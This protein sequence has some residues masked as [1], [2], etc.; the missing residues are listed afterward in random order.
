MALLTYLKEQIEKGEPAP[1]IPLEFACGRN[2]I[3]G[4]SGGSGSSTQLPLHRH[5]YYEIF[6][7]VSDKISHKVDDKVMRLA[8]NTIC[9]VRPDDAH[10][11]IYPADSSDERH[12]LNITFSK[13]V[14]DHVFT[15]LQETGINREDFLN[16]KEPPMRILS[17]MQ[18]REFLLEFEKRLQFYAAE[19]ET[20]RRNIY[21]FL[22]YIFINFFFEPDMRR[23]EEVSHPPYWL[24]VTCEKMKRMEN[25]YEGLPRMVELSGKS[26]EYLARS[27]KKYYGVTTSQFINDLRL[28]YVLGRLVRAEDDSDS[29]LEII[30]DSGFQSPGHFYKLFTEKYGM[31]P[32]EYR[33][34]KMFQPEEEKGMGK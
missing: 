9:L 21:G 2:G 12:I 7:V 30:L 26:Q 29:M 16:P 33:K 27:M 13:E 34:K 17:E 19:G 4:F 14:F 24:E 18:G 10:T 23:S 5:E 20:L 31:T 3:F 6:L 25:F 11:H 15:F 1:R 32:K 22:V 28:S 8:K